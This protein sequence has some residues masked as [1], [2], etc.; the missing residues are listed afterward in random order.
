MCCCG[1]IK[2]HKKYGEI[3]QFTGDQREALTRRLV[4]E[5]ITSKDRVKIH[6]Y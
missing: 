1:T 2:N 5:K 4:V 6:G 3:A